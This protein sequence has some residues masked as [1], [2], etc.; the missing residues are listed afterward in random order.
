MVY[1]HRPPAL[2]LQRNRP[3]G[4]YG[5]H[6]CLCIGGYIRIKVLLSIS[7]VGRAICIVGLGVA[8]MHHR[9]RLGIRLSQVYFKLCCTPFSRSQDPQ[10]FEDPVSEKS[11]CSSYI[12][13][14]L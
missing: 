3:P 1:L 4:N 8:C 10:L 9:R 5:L 11:E 13:K 6:I 14:F 7:F 12:N 2:Y